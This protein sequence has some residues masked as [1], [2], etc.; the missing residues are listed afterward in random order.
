MSSAMVK[1]EWKQL[2]TITATRVP[3]SCLTSCKPT[4]DVSCIAAAVVNVQVVSIVAPCMPSS[5][6]PCL[7][8]IQM[9][10]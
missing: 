10:V 1:C 6:H 8:P 3:D 5:L 4:V 9:V 7:M 2:A